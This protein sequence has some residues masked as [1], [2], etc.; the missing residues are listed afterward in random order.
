MKIIYSLNEF[1]QKAVEISGKIADHVSVRVDFCLFGK[2]EFSCYA[3]GYDRYTGKTMEEAL[4]KMQEAITPANQKIIDVEINE[5]EN[6]STTA[7]DSNMV[8]GPTME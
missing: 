1:H 3:D 6:T 2:K 5:N 7:Q 4:N 8:A